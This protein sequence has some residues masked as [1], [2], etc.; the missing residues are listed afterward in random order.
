MEEQLDSDFDP[1]EGLPSANGHRALEIYPANVAIGPKIVS[2]YPNLLVARLKSNLEEEGDPEHSKR[3]AAYNFFVPPLT[4]DE[5]GEERPDARGLTALE[6]DEMRDEAWGRALREFHL[7]YL[8]KHGIRRYFER[9]LEAD[10][11]AFGIGSMQDL[12]EGFLQVA[13]HCYEGSDMDSDKLRERLQRECVGE[14]GYQTFGERGFA[15]DDF[16]RLRTRQINIPWTAL[17]EASR[18]TSR[19]VMAVVSGE[20]KAHAVRVSLARNLLIYNVLITDS[21]VAESLVETRS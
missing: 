21:R 17:R 7:D 6:S 13:Q 1:F 12:N 14:I 10:I 4:A 20:K 8:A 19:T 11:F 2:Y 18:D 9:A 16:V 15:Q 3:I 5:E